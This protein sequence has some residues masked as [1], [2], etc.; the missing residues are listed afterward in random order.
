MAS[1]IDYDIFLHVD[2]EHKSR[3]E[4]YLQEHDKSG[5]RIG[6][7]QMPWKWGLYF[8]ASELVS[9][10]QININA[11]SERR[12]TESYVSITG[13][14]RPG[15]YFNGMFHSANTK[16]RMFGKSREIENFDLYIIPLRDDDGEE[17]A[18]AGAFGY[19]YN[20]DRTGQ[21]MSD[22]I[23]I[24]F[25]LK[26]DRVHDL[27]NKIE[28]KSI[29]ALNISVD[30]LSGFYSGW[31]PKIDTD[32]VKVLT[33]NIEHKIVRT[34][35]C[36]IN[37]PVLGDVGNFRLAVISSHGMVFDV[38]VSEKDGFSDKSAYINSEKSDVSD[39]LLQIDAIFHRIFDKNIRM[40][41]APIWLV[42]IM[43][44]FIFMK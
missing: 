40:I 25:H 43:V 10:S 30:H 5:S 17:Y 6:G 37:P 2:A 12:F 28:N 27:I 18:S 20:D 39:L 32:D 38:L 7:P 33:D 44:I 41:L 16:Y 36:M 19:A 14:L 23:Q 29:K 1:I 4:W 3:C 42:L 13:K 35:S 15:S 31:T 24:Q 34:D 8:Y 11:S 26:N 22:S 9:C 21:V